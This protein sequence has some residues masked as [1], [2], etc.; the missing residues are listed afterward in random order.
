VITLGF[1]VPPSAFIWPVMV[2]KALKGLVTFCGL[3][4]HSWLLTAGRSTA[5]VVRPG[6]EIV[7]WR[8]FTLLGKNPLSTLILTSIVVLVAEEQPVIAALDATTAA[9]HKSLKLE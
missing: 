5:T 4:T 1:D 3:I 7:P 2:I 8:L 9:S 6:A